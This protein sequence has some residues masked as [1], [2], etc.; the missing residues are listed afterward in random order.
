MEKMN[1]NK[2]NNIPL[3][4]CT[5]ES[6]RA[7]LESMGPPIKPKY[8]I[9]KMDTNGFTFL[10]VEK[11]A[12]MFFSPTKVDFGPPIEPIVDKDLQ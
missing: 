10:E 11:W 3:G 12:E 9:C 1:K 2:L 7:A 6:M 4:R 5:A 8:F